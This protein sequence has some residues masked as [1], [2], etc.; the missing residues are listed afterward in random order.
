MAE[1][2]DLKRIALV[3]GADTEIGLAI[4][5]DLARQGVRVLLAS[6]DIEKSQRDSAELLKEGWDVL[7][8]QLDTTDDSTVWALCGFIQHKFGRLDILINN[9]NVSPSPTRSLPVFEQLEEI[10]RRLVT[11]THRLIDALIPLLEEVG[12]SNIVNIAPHIKDFG[13]YAGKSAMCDSLIMPVYQASIAA[14]HSLTVSYAA[15]LQPR[16]IK[17]NTVSLENVYANS[18]T[19]PLRTLAQTA[20]LAVKVAVSGRDGPTGIFENKYKALVV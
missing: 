20:L 17:V 10:F 8:I 11:G 14:L 15:Q 18:A 16:G 9:A 4:A 13:I 1:Q 7:P 2:R 3:N 12:S 6:Q 5:A 19:S